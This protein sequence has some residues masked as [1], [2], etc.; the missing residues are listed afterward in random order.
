MEPLSN[1]TS[2]TDLLSAPTIV[3]LHVQ[4]DVSRA[5]KCGC[6]N[7]VTQVFAGRGPHAGEFRCS[8]CGAFRGWLS[9]STAIWLLA[10][11][12]KF[13]WPAADQPIIIRDRTDAV[14]P[15]QQ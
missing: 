11:I 3:G 4:L 1:K 12:S 9:K 8:K 7:A 6:D 13:G 10:V 14:P 15:V 2:T 5:P